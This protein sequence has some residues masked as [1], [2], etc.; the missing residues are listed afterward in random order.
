MELKE[1]RSKIDVL[2]RL[3]VDLL[4]QRLSMSRQIGMEKRFSGMEIRDKRREKELLEAIGSF[5]EPKD[6]EAVLKIYQAILKTSVAEQE[7]LFSEDSA[8]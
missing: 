4:E 2:D 5:C 7:K 6:K 3:I 1:A 8:E